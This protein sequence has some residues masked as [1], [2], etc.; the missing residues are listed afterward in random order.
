MRQPT[1]SSVL[2]RRSYLGDSRSRDMIICETQAGVLVSLCSLSGAAIGFEQ[3]TDAGFVA[4]G[5]SLDNE[6]AVKPID[7]T[8][9]GK[10]Q[11]VSKRDGSRVRA[12]D[13]ESKNADFAEY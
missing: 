6:C 10:A 4:I 8:G 11:T 13:A 1:N 9:L 2:L 3:I 12:F 5:G 7:E